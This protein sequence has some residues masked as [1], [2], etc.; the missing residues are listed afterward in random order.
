MMLVFF[1]CLNYRTTEF[2]SHYNG[3]FC[4]RIIIAD[5]LKFMMENQDL[6]ATQ[7]I[8]GHETVNFYAR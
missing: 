7:F 8:L 6:F 2:L 5:V 3:S 1:H 4:I